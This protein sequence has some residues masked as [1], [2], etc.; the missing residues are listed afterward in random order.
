MSLASMLEAPTTRIE[1][2]AEWLDR[3]THAERLEAIRTL[4]RSHQR[5]LYTRAS[6]SPAIT[7]EHFVPPSRPDR[8]EVRHH[9]KNTLPVPDVFRTFEKRFC[10][11][12]DGTQRL[13]GYNEG[14]ALQWLGPGYFVARP[15]ADNPVWAARGD[16]VIDYF[17]VPDGPVVETWPPVVPNTRGLQ[18]FVYHKTRDFM[19]RVSQHVSIGAAYR[20]ERSLDHYFVLV[21][22]DV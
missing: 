20:V 4:H 5:T 3:R 6:L 16:V 7:L 14:A 13:F 2:I 18:R 1:E 12:A 21:R 17:E 9:G 11:P 15:T 8:T 22:E 10:R 19:R